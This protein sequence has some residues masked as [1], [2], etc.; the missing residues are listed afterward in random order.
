MKRKN[1]QDKLR[2]KLFL[3]ETKVIQGKKEILTR[4]EGAPFTLGNKT[5]MPSLINIIE[6]FSEDAA[7]AVSKE[8]E[9]MDLWK[10]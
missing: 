7:K 4:R 5:K 2:E 6:I 10:G 1:A 3:K 9:I 8:M